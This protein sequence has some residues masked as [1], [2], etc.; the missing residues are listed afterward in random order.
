MAVADSIA[1]V[2]QQYKHNLRDTTVNINYY[3]FE[4]ERD[5]AFRTYYNFQ[6][7]Q[8]RL[9]QQQKLW[10]RTSVYQPTFYLTK[11]SMSFDYQQ[12]VQSYQPFTGGTFVFS[13]GMN[14][15]T[16]LQ[17]NELFENYRIFGGFRLNSDLRSVEYL[18]SF[19]DLSRRLD[20]QVLFHRNA[21][22][23]NLGFVGYNYTMTKTTVNELLLS[24]RYPFNQVASLR[25]TVLGRY[26][27]EIYLATDNGVYTKP[28][29][30]SYFASAKFEFIY[31][32]TRQLSLNLYDGVRSKVFLEGYRQIG[33]N[34]YWTAIT[35]LDFRFY[36][37]LWR[38]MIFAWRVAASTNTGSGKLVYYLGGVDYWYVLSL[39]PL[40]T[41]SQMFYK[42]VNINYDNNYIFQAVATPMRG[43]KQNIRN[44][45]TFMLMNTEIRM[46]VFQMLFDS[47]VSSQFLHN[48][49]IVGFFDVG[50]AWCGKSPSDPCNV[51]N[52]YYAYNPPVTMVVDI[53]RPPVVEGVGFGLRSKLLGYFIRMDFAWGIEANYVHPMQFYL[54]LS[55]DF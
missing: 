40:Q 31:D 52:Q 34:K 36:K 17:I 14:L 25:A 11:M 47:P 18:A 19:E 7:Q 10:G 2:M 16:V 53:E 1:R 33:G 5:S 46:P 42:D 38:N 26:D 21:I 24:V 37:N 29:S 45:T 48:F 9:K 41:G 43:F 30:S 54:S 44:G 22:Y 23:Q 32:N 13:P 28:G 12:L 35:G 8:K 4:I 15:F 39:N 6:L 3:V 27:R 51:Y 20:K 55:Y 49:Q 50:S